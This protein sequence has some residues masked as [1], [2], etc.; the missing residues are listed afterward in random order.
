[1]YFKQFRRPLKFSF[2]III[3]I[4]IFNILTAAPTNTP[5]TSDRIK[6]VW[7]S[8]VGNSLLTYTSAIDN[9]FYRLSQQNYNT[10]YVDVYNGGTTYPSKYSSRNKLIS[11]PFTDPLQTAI[12]EGKRQG[13]HIYAWYEHGMML[14]PKQKLA[15]QHPDWILTTSDGKQYIEKHLWLDP[16]KIEVQQ[17]FVNLFT[18]VA[19][20]YPELYGIQVDDHWGIPIVFGDKTQAMTELTRQ[21]V[22]AVKQTSPN[23]IISLSPNPYQFS[24]NKYSLDWTRWI[25]EKLF[26]ELVIQI[27]RPDSQQV[28]ESILT[29]GIK[30]ASQ[31]VKVAVGIYAGGDPQLKSLSEID[32]QVNVV[33]K[34]DYGYSIFSWEYTSIFLRKAIYLFRQLLQCHIA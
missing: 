9:V 7:L 21:I 31:Y 33:K 34:F 29:S 16:E 5:Q 27:Y 13:L 24:V 12:K 19:Q 15:Q 10:V 1:M 6:G 20:K 28:T 2:T 18:E 26:D 14:F 8:H 32:R 23:L 11:F 25:E 22:R 3:G 30:E 4:I 17:Y